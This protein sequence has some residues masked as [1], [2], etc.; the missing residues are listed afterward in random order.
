VV[1]LSLGMLV[2]I[3]NITDN[4]YELMNLGR[5]EKAPKWHEAK[6]KVESPQKFEEILKWLGDNVQGVKK[7][8][9]W[10]LTDGGILEIRFR[11]ERDFEWFVLRWQ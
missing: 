9:V 5:W 7:H 4:L 6:I 1:C 11:Y 2:E 10:R 3:K 8:T